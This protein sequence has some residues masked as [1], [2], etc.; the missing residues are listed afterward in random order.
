MKTI[1]LVF[2]ILTLLFLIQCTTNNILQSEYVGADGIIL[3][4][5]GNTG[6]FKFDSYSLNDIKIVGDSMIINLSYSGGC[7]DHEFYLIAKN[8][9]GNSDSPKA[10]LVLSHDNKMDPCEAYPTEDHTFVLLPLKY[11]YNKKF[12]KETGKILLVLDEKEIEYS[13]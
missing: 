4:N 8:Y 7:R 2:T 10:E 1:N 11:E 9:F 3:G 12:G 6:S 13:F 5:I